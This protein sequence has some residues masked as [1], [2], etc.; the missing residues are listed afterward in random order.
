MLCRVINF[1]IT[2]Q[3]FGIIPV[4]L[5]LRKIKKIFFLNYLL[6]NFFSDEW[7][8][9]LPICWLILCVFVSFIAVVTANPFF[10]DKKVLF[11][12]YL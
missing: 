8:T 3:I 9:F 10:Y 12:S 7:I 2:F 6:N 4:Q 11:K 5:D 1:L